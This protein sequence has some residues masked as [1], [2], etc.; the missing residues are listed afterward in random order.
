MNTSHKHVDRRTA[1]LLTLDTEPYLSCVE[2][3]DRMDAYVEALLANPDHD[4][5]RM[6]VHLDA[7]P[8]CAEEA[9]SLLL[10]VAED[11][12]RWLTP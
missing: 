10:L 7:C 11:D 9:A 12:G 6:R 3:F 1:R 2:C 8:A 5:K 4:D